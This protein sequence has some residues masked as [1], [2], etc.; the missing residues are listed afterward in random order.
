[1]W[2]YSF[3]LPFTSLFNPLPS[4]MRAFLILSVLLWGSSL[5]SG[6]KITI[7]NPSLPNCNPQGVL[8]PNAQ[9]FMQSSLDKNKYNQQIILQ[10]VNNYELQR[11][12]NQQQIDIDRALR[13]IDEALAPKGSSNARIKYD[14]PI[15]T[16]SGKI[17]FQNAQREIMEMVQLKSPYDLKRAVYLTEFAYDNSLSYDLFSRQIGKLV[18]IIRLEMKQRKI[19][20]SDNIGKI[21]AIFKFMADTLTVRNPVLEKTITTYPKTYDFEDFYGM[22]DYHKMFV[23]K[24]IRTGKGQCHSL[25]LLFLILC[26]EIGAKAYLSTGPE[27]YYIKFMDKFGS[28]QNIE[29]TNQMFTTDQFILQS[30]FIK[31]PAIKNRIYMDTLAMDKVILG[32]LND[33][34]NCYAKKYG[35]DDFV[36]QCADQ[37][38]K[39][40]TRNILAHMHSANYFNLLWMKVQNQY[41]SLGVPKEEFRKDRQLAKIATT[42]IRYN[43]M[44]DDLGYAEMPPDL[45]AKWLNSL[46]NESMRQQHLDR[47]RLLTNMIEH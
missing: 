21:M 5:A 30:G 6:Q 43:R 27:H 12:N 17:H 31:A 14:F 9:Y 2:K 7:P 36:L 1:M 28:L 13:D 39:Y 10:E 47:K 24:L 44:I 23:S 42:A 22:R 26:Q 37:V 25:P 33:L 35:Y 34:S 32:T 11:Q 19:S 8:I 16:S 3:P 20:P 45:Y 38:L 40:D 18:E 15:N 4:A 46:K 41:D 29:L